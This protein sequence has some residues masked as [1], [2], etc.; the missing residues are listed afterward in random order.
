MIAGNDKYNPFLPTILIGWANYNHYELLMPLNMKEEEYPIEN[1]LLNN[2][3]NSKAYE[4]S[5]NYNINK[6]DQSKLTKPI[7]ND[8][9]DKNQ[10]GNLYENYKTELTTCLKTSNLF[11]LH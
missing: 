3:E 10:S 4:I 2:I 6:K 5:K 1:F 11:I 7:I 8:T 9:I